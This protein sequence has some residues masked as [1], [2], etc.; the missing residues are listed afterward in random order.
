V[1][2]ASSVVLAVG[3]GGCD[4]Q[5][6]AVSTTSAE[7][8]LTCQAGKHREFTRPVGLGVREFPRMIEQVSSTIVGNVSVVFVSR[9]PGRRLELF[10]VLIC[11]CR[12]LSV[13]R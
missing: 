1:R 10:T 8:L 3:S 13:C 12:C 2:I 9:G 6:A 4:Q 7:L 5:V 11:L